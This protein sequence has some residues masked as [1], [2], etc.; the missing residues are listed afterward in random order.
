MSFIHVQ[1]SIRSTTN[2]RFHSQHNLHVKY[3][4]VLLSETHLT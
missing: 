3:T 4:H 1:Y 2:V